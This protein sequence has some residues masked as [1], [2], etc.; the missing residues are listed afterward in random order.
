MPE[1]VERKRWLCAAVAATALG[2][3]VAG[4]AGGTAV[5]PRHCLWEVSR[6]EQRLYMAGSIHFLKAEHYPLP[7]AI[8]EAYRNSEVLVLEID[9]NSSFGDGQQTR[10]LVAG[11]FADER[12]LGEGLHSET[13]RKAQRCVDEMGLNML[14]FEK[15]K[16]WM[17]AM[18]LAALKLEALGFQSEHG[19]DWHFLR[20]ARQDGKPV[21]ALETLEAQLGLFEELSEEQQDLFV[22][23]TVEDLARFESQMET[24]VDAWLHGDMQAIDATLLDAFRDTPELY[25]LFVSDRNAAWVESIEAYLSSGRTHFLVAGAGHMAGRD[26]L[27]ALLRARGYRVQQK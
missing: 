17:F 26:G 15:F 21:R 1:A 5:S 14:M 2:A 10:M 27:P 19:M 13:L 12:T 6:G 24:V 7:A 22:R 16:P 25:A 18:T 23:R 4:A 3:G 8:E 9:M 20:R 11:L